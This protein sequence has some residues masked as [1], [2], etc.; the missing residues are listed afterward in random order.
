MTEGK[1]KWPALVPA[2]CICFH[3]RACVCPDAE[4][5]LRHISAGRYTMNDAER[6]W[7]LAEIDSV[8]G[9][10]RLDHVGATDADIARGVLGAW[11]DYCRD[12][13]LI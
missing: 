9:H 13:G 6:E 12:K 11:T 2:E 8:E 3:S 7:C 10:S 1:G 5:A 4:R